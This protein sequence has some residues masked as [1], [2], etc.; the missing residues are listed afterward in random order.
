[1]SW[2]R[3]NWI[4]LGVLLAYLGMGANAILLATFG[5]SKC[6]IFQVAILIIGMLVFGTVVVPRLSKTDVLVPAAKPVKTTRLAWP[7]KRIIEV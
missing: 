3:E 7:A 1:M 6:A 4:C 5:F 2:T